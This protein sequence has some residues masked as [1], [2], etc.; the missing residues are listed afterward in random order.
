MSACI[1]AD[2][3]QE[4][5][6]NHSHLRVIGLEGHFMWRTLQA[7]REGEGRGSVEGPGGTWADLFQVS[8]FNPFSS[9]H[10]SAGSAQTLRLIEVP[11]FLTNQSVSTPTLEG[12]MGGCVSKWC[13]CS[14]SLQLSNVTYSSFTEYNI[15]NKE[16]NFKLQRHNINVQSLRQGNK[17]SCGEFKSKTV[18]WNEDIP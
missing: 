17:Q 3:V 14:P 16:Y 2:S 6:I 13:F 10:P 5:F 12:R 15:N 7:D 8:C 1:A 9:A 4:G 18:S 11:A